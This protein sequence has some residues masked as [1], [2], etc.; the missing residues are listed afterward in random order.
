MQIVHSVIH[1]FDKEQHGPIT[2]VVMKEVLLDNSLPAVVT[3]VQG[4]QKL[5]GN[6]SNSQ[7]W[8]KFG[9]NARVGRFP[10]ALH[11]YI[12]HQDD[13]GQFLAL[14]Q[15]VVTELVTE[16]TKKQASTG[17]RILFSLFI[18]DDAGPIFMVAMIKQ[19]GGVSLNKDFVPTGITEIDLSKL[20]QAAQIRIDHY[21]RVESAD[22]NADIDRNYLSFLAPK[23]AVSASEYFI[24]ALGC[25]LG[26]TSAKA[27]DLLFKAVDAFFQA[28]AV[29]VPFR[30]SAK[31]SITLYLQKQSAAGVPA[32]LEEI[33]DVMK[34]AG[35][36]ENK[37]HFSAVN[38]FLN[39]PQFKIPNEFV[40]HD[41][42]LKNHSKVTLD[43]DRISLKF[44]RSDLGVGA[45]AAI[46]YDREQRTLTIKDLSPEFMA[47]LDKTLEE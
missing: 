31:E 25:E 27:T 39:G 46:K 11:G 8:G 22:P 12:A 34:H 23:A 7:A 13:A 44:V 1:G 9:D 5:L 43:N 15:L 41:R 28:N 30:K 14:T 17:G 36:P 2:D 29:L 20:H 40:V 4:V 33:C 10:P 6:S 35:L 47:K 21:L 16:A 19:K 45:N 26:L 3:L 18:D 42:V 24:M 38:E 32:T 37:E